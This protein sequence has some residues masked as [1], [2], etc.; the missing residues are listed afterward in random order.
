MLE[1]RR[2]FAV[3]VT[4]LAGLRAGKREI[5][6]LRELTDE[7]HEKRADTVRFQALDYDFIQMLAK[8]SENWVFRLITNSVRPIYDERPELFVALVADAD[9]VVAGYRAVVDALDEGDGD[10][11]A[12]EI[13]K[14]M[15]DGEAKLEAALGLAPE[16]KGKKR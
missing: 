2:I 5:A 3:E 14:V 9:R 11:A 4:R 10:R 7:M 12:K 1:S 15:R 6:K 8:A 13:E 16:K